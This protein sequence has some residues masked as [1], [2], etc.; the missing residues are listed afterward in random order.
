MFI[1]SLFRHVSFS[2]FT[3]ILRL[4]PD[5]VFVTQIKTLCLNLCLKSP[6]RSTLS[7]SEERSR[8]ERSRGLVVH[9]DYRCMVAS[10][11]AVLLESSTSIAK[12]SLH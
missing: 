4:R 8:L 6:S 2:S 10:V 12:V 5:V 7:E 3:S 9:L 1:S 11:S